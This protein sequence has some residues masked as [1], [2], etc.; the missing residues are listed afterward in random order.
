[1]DAIKPANK[2][3]SGFYYHSE[4]LLFQFILY[5]FLHTHGDIIKMI[6]LAAKFSFVSKEKVKAGVKRQVLCELIHISQHLA[7]SSYAYM[8]L[9]SWNHEG[10]ILHKLNNYCALFSRLS[11]LDPSQSTKFYQHANQ[12]WISCIRLHDLF[13]SML[14]TPQKNWS[15]PLSNFHAQM[16]RL[17]NGIKRFTV[18][19]AQII[20][21][22][23]NDENIIFFILR[24]A[25]EFDVIYNQGFVK[26]LFNKISP[27]GLD[28]LQNSIVDKYKNRGFDNLIPIINTKFEEI[29]VKP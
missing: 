6:E 22:Y 28:Y 9:F 4:S 23:S 3:T 21:K 19:L 8:R 27:D 12:M 5:D 11:T 16:A 15:G 17:T 29:L 18:M 14:D 7:G 20:P 26:N 13:C 24:H 1:M 10:E 25:N 2:L